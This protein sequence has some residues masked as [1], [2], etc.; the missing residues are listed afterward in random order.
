[1]PMRAKVSWVCHTPPPLRKRSQPSHAV[2]ALRLVALTGQGVGLPAVARLGPF[3][4]GRPVGL[5]ADLAITVGF[6]TLFFAL[7]VRSFS[8][9]MS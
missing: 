2:D 7:A 9:P 1:M 8:R 3:L 5:A 6:T 4:F